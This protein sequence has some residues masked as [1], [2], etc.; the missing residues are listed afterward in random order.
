MT[1]RDFV[2]KLFK[3]NQTDSEIFKTLVRIYGHSKIAGFWENAHE[4]LPKDSKEI[5]NKK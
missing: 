4:S 1:L 2:L 5:K 3:D